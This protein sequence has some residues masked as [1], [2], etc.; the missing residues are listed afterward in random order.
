MITSTHSDYVPTIDKSCRNCIH[1]N[2]CMANNIY[3]DFYKDFKKKIPWNS[4]LPV[5]DQLAFCCDEFIV[6]PGVNVDGT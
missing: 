6:K 3:T 4:S 2:V 1:A 5:P